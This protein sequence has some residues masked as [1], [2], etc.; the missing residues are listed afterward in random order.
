MNVEDSFW[1]DVF[2]EIKPTDLDL[3]IKIYRLAKGK[4]Q[5]KVKRHYE[6]E[7]TKTLHTAWEPLGQ[8]R[9]IYI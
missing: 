1:S 4:D 6:S 8:L 9:L 2:C 5:L 7:A 3:N